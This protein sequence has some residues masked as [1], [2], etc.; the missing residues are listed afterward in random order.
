MNGEPPKAESVTRHARVIAALLI[1][2]LAAGPAA[3]HL[4]W[5]LGGTWGLDGA[6]SSTGIR[7]VAAIVVLLIVAAMLVVLARVGLWQQR[8]VSDRVIRILAWA[9]AAFFLVHAL[10][11]FAEGWA[12]IADK[13]VVVRSERARDRTARAR[14]RRLGRNPAAFPP[15]APDSAVALKGRGGTE[16]RRASLFTSRS[17]GSGLRPRRLRQGIASQG[18]FGQRRQAMT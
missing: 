10:A 16:F 7:I 18:E 12:G 17:A 13:I 3:T 5:M 14:R 1:V 6:P 2:A 4:H 9:F 11:S 8:L 15:A